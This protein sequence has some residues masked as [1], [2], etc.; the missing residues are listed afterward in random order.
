VPPTKTRV[1]ATPKP[2][3]TA[4]PQPT[5]A[6]VSVVD[7]VPIDNGS[8]G[9]EGIYVQYDKKDG[10]II[11]TGS[12]GHKYRCEFGFLNSA[13]SLATIQQFWSYAQRG[14]G[15]WKMLVEVNG[16]VSWISC[17]DDANVCYETS[18]NS[19][20]ASFMVKIYLKT[21]VWQS[22]LNDYIAGGLNQALRNGYYYEVQNG[23]FRPM[24]GA[25]P[26]VACVGFRFIRLD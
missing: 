18:T 11:V 16:K 24:C 4:V 5:A 15:N 19:G 12:D 13:Q 10:D 1:P 21:H 23:I 17:D 9:K 2:A 20:G 7:S 6:P 22:L 25:V 3:A 14:G 26:D 8:W